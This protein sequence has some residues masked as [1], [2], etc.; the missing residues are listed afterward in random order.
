MKMQTRI[1]LAGCFAIAMFNHFGTTGVDV[2]S[3]IDFDSNENEETLGNPTYGT[4]MN[5]KKSVNPSE[6]ILRAPESSSFI[7]HYRNGLVKASEP[8]KRRIYPSHVSN[9]HHKKIIT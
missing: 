8:R 7:W 2:S 3:K 9:R 6:S 1:I 5:P 4:T